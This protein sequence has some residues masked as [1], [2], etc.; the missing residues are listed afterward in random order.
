MLILTKTR[1]VSGL[2]RVGMAAIF[3]FVLLLEVATAQVPAGRALQTP[4]QL[5]DDALAAYDSKDFAR[6]AT[7]F[8]LACDKGLPNACLN[9]AVQY[10]TGRGVTADP[11]RGLAMFDRSCTLGNEDGCANA[12]TARR[13]M[14]AA[15]AAA[16]PAQ[17]AAPTTTLAQAVQACTTGSQPDCV[18][19]GRAYTFGQEGVAANATLAMPSLIKA[20]EGGNMFSCWYAGHNYE[21]GEGVTANL[22]QAGIYYERACNGGVILGGCGNLG[23]FYEQGALYELAESAFG[24]VCAISNMEYCGKQ[25]EMLHRLGRVDEALKLSERACASNEGNACGFAGYIYAGSERWDAANVLYTKAC[26]LGTDKHCAYARQLAADVERRRAWHAERAAERAEASR[27]IASGNIAEAADY[28][29]Y[30]LKSGPLAREVVETAMRRNA[31]GALNIQTLYVLASWFRD[32]AVSAAVARQLQARGTG[33]E[34]TFGTGTNA[35]GAAESRWRAANGGA[36]SAYG[37]YRPAASTVPAPA[38]LSTSSAS[39]QTRL[40]YRSAH[41]EMRG[42]NRSSPN[43]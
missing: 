28:A 32:G 43:C 29:V 22:A 2:I 9:L 17:P 38:Q 42:S 18:R 19:A 40:R 23:S 30:Q 15:A 25:A 8:Q 14:S 39:E 7:L 36:A 5:F 41:C 34:G 33:L 21:G 10:M 11:A 16:R 24:K 3:G 26:R 1:A 4:G 12:T 6:S 20:C 35:P 37:G 31:M 27:L 13:R